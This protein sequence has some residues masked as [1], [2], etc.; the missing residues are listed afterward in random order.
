MA[1]KNS[2]NPQENEGVYARFPKQGELGMKFGSAF[3][4][5]LYII[6]L[7]LI[8]CFVLVLKFIE[9]NVFIGL[10][11]TIVFFAGVFFL[12][13]EIKSLM[14]KNFL[15]FVKSELV[16]P[17]LEHTSLLGQSGKAQKPITDLPIVK[18][19]II[20]DISS[21]TKKLIK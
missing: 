20:E 9:I 19:L 8:L 13:K 4:N 18:Q 6:L 12:F 7:A 15:L 2:I 1:K 21:K 14:E 17:I 16:L 11:F 5:F 3:G 10:F